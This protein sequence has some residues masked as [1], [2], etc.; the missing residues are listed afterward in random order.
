MANNRIVQVKR[1]VVTGMGLVSPLGQSVPESWDRLL[2]G[3]SGISR[4][5]GI[6]PE[7]PI[8]GPTPPPGGF[9]LDRRPDQGF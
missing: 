8:W 6:S 2:R 5:E 9:S 4:L 1:V 7:D 3:R